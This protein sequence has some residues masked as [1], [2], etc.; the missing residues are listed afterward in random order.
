VIPGV[1]AAGDDTPR[2]AASPR[3]MLAGEASG[4]NRNSLAG[5]DSSVNI[6]LRIYPASS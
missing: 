2:L 1:L 5:G 3:L 6:G 4:R